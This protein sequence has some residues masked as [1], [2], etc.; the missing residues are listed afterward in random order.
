MFSIKN[1]KI[2]IKNKNI[3]LLF[4]IKNKNNSLYFL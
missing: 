4:M 1:P 2:Y 3:K